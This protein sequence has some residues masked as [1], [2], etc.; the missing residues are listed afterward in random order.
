MKRIFYWIEIPAVDFDRAVNFYSRLLGEELEKLDWGTEKMACLP[1]D[2]GAISY[3]PD[4]KPSV[5]GVLASF[6]TGNDI[7]GWI[8]RIEEN[9]GKIVRPKDTI[10]EE[11]RGWFALFHDTEGNRLGLYGET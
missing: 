1:D 7:D 4:F 5:D 3:S 9:G 2:A 10:D 8:K 11:G 6:N